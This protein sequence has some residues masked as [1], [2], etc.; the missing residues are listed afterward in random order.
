MCVGGTWRQGIGRRRCIRECRRRSEAR[1][2]CGSGFS[3]YVLDH[4]IVDPAA[5]RALTFGDGSRRFQPEAHADQPP[6]V[7]N[8][9]HAVL[10]PSWRIARLEIERAPRRA[11]VHADI[12]RQLVRAG[13]RALPPETDFRLRCLS[14]SD[15][16]LD[17]QRAG[18]IA[19][20]AVYKPACAA[21]PG[22]R[23]ET[24]CALSL[25]ALLALKW[26]DKRQLDR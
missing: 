10:H 18:Y 21:V 1:R 20:G 8:E 17:G 16:C 19:L 5:E 14:Q 15:L 26:F 4:E 22:L 6:L 3:G 13:E 25:P 2:V 24:P 11:I 12:D 23:V 9:A 7:G